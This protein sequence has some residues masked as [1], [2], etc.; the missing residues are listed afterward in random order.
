MNVGELWELIKDEKEQFD[1]RYLAQLAFGGDVTDEHLSGLVRAL[2]EDRLYFRMKDGHFVP[3]TEE[4]VDQII[5][6]REEEAHREER[7]TKG[8][9]W[10]KDLM[11]GKPH[12][13]PSF[14]D[15]IVQLVTDLVL[16][17]TEA[18]QFKFAKELLTQAGIGD[19]KQARALLVKMGVWDEDENLDLIRIHVTASFGEAALAES[20][21]LASAE[22]SFEGRED[23]THLSVMTIDGPYS[24]D[25][26]DGLSLE[27]D[28]ESLHL[29]IHIADVAAANP[30]WNE[31]GR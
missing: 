18:P 14:K 29:G 6:Q 3:N 30:A 8:A 7:L 26:D 11:D 22:K 23:L 9:Q 4:R 24:R 21:R 12:E 2:F 20:A 15:E 17:D 5:R 25:F 31:P 1:Y 10:L 16:Y 27:R 28:G 19:L 13:P